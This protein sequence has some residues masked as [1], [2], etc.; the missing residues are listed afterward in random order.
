[1]WY[2]CSITIG[3]FSTLGH[4]MVTK[5]CDLIVRHHHREMIL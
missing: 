3:C 1:M 5:L 4:I 2:M